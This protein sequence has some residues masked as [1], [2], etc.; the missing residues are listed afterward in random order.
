MALGSLTGCANFCLRRAADDGEVEFETQAADFI[1]N[2]FYVDDGLK[3]VSTEE[4]AVN[5]IK[6]SQGICARAG[7]QLHKIMS[8][9]KAVLES[10]P[11]DERAKGV[12][13][14]DL[15][16]D[17]LPMKRVLGVMWCVE[18]DTFQFRIELRDR[19]FTRRGSIYDPS[20]Y[21]APV[22]L[23]GKQILQQMC[24][25]KLDWDSPIPDS[26]RPLWQR[27]RLECLD[28]GP[29]TRLIV[30]S[31]LPSLVLSKLL[32]CIQFSD[33]SEEGYGQCTN[34]RL[35]NESDEA[36]CSFV[37]G[38]ARVT[39]LKQVTIPRLELTAATMSARMSEFLRAE[40][41]Y[42]NIKEFF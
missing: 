5:L 39:P 20:G 38:K 7:L 29:D 42:Q 23:K 10:V 21:V 25:D 16:V 19:P 1:K 3:S 33:A 32:S 28:L 2:N 6:A 9:K 22:S 41:T 26:C 4:E 24:R 30:A 27:W 11:A 13:D 31:N 12:K 37:I 17:P 36:H 35:V 34:L 18:N 15:K 40:L 8:N 14:I